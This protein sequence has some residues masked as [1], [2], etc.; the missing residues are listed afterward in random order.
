[1]HH[2]QVV[3]DLPIKRREV[4]GSLKAGDASHELLLAEETHPDVV[5]KLR[6]LG[7][8]ALS[9]SSVFGLQK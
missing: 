8:F 7:Q 4:V 5:P 3:Q 1:M 2:A 9:G 6:R